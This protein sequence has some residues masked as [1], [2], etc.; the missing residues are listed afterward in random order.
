MDV[1]IWGGGLRDYM[2]SRYIGPYKIAHW[3]RKHGYD[4]QVIDFTHAL[5]K[6]DL[7]K[8]TK[9]FVTSDTRIL[10][11][12]TTFLG[13]HLYD[14]S[15]GSKHNLPEALVEVAKLIK[16]ENPNI[17]IIMGG[18]KAD[19]MDGFGVVDASIMSYTT[20]S[21]DI[22]I[23]YLDH[24]VKGSEPPIGET[25]TP[26]LGK[27]GLDKPRIL[28][29]QARNP[30]YSIEQDDF[31][32]V[33]QD[34]ILPGEPLPLDVSRGCIFA[35]RFCQYPHLGKGKL[36]Y[37]R[38][39]EYLEQEVRNNY[40]NYGTTSYYILDDTFNDTEIKLQAFYDMTQR[41]PF[42]ISYT[43]YIRADLIDAYP[44]TAHLLKESGLFGAFHGIES[45][46][47]E[48]SKLV[49]KGWSGRR[50][51]EFLPKLYHDIWQGQ[52]PQHLNFIIGITGET[53]ESVLDS[54]NWFIENDMHS[55]KFQ[56]LGL[57]GVGDKTSKYT[58]QSEFDKNA[59]KYG[60][61]FKD[62]FDGNLRTW[63]NGYW[64]KKSAFDMAKEVTTIVDK[65][66]RVQ[67]WG[68][69]ALEWFGW[70]KETL[71]TI[72]FLDI[73]FNTPI[74]ATMNRSKREKYYELLL[75]L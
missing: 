23:E 29:D 72:K 64:T 44:N 46:H 74:M 67:V 50:G 45:L 12:S 61:K 69:P 2:F 70:K 11:I 40:E 57:F 73:P 63:T 7:Y 33:A 60:Y 20:A 36:D 71:R 22:F 49:G 53:R 25:I 15:D 16:N 5:N 56:G 26:K 4:A 32:F 39:M 18:Y 52:V 24:L 66:R 35:C 6:E 14:W 17:K 19:I 30:V 27:L 37:I 38:G 51:K 13:M 10:A 31:R 48:A 55:I 43:S 28:Y 68:L 54:V 8:I 41:L 3:I 59:E 9:H 62:L 42:K 34:C 1:I 21:E 47:P 75:Q 65:H 58:I